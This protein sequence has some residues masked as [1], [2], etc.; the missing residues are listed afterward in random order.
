[1]RIL[2]VEDD[3]GIAASLSKRLRSE[4][5]AVDV[6]GDGLRGEEMA[7][8]NDNDLII[9]DVLLPRQDGWQTC[10]NLRRKGVPTPILMLTALDGVEE[11]IRGLDCGADDYITKP[12]HAGELLAR[13]RSLTRRRTEVR[14]AAVEKFG[15]VLDLS[16]RRASRQGR[17]IA[18]TA[19]E[20]ALLELF[21]MHPGQVLT[22][23]TISEHLWDMN[24]Q[25]RSNVIESFVKFLR[26]KLDRGFDTPLIHTV[27]GAGYLFSDA[28]P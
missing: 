26:H 16:T 6:T 12:Y 19:R 10:E 4:G 5:Y 3:A 22:R 7:L 11:T 2:I 21:M 27:R 20:F 9:L 15:V 1:M 24:Y 18:L 28:Q 13:I 14:A 23:A 8:T 17:D 25:P